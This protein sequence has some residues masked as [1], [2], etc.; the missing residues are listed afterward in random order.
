[1]KFNRSN[2]KSKQRGL[3]LNPYRYATSGPPPSDAL[4]GRVVVLQH[5]D[6]ADGSTTFTDSSGYAKTWSVSG[7]AQI[8]SAQSVFGGSSGQFDG[9]G[10][11]IY[12]ADFPELYLGTRNFTIEGRAR[13]TGAAATQYLMGQC[14]A[15]GLNTTLSI[16]IS[17][18]AT[19][20][21]KA[22]CCSG[23]TEIGAC[24]SA[25]QAVDTWFA[26]SYSRRGATFTLAINGVSVATATSSAAVNNSVD[27]FAIGCL[28][29]FN[30]LYFNGWQDEVRFTIGAAR[31]T[32]P[33]TLE[34]VQF[35]TGPAGDPYYDITS[36]LLHGD[37]TDGS[38]TFTD[39]SGTPKT[40]TVNGNAQIDTAQSQFGGASMLF[41]G[42]GDWLQYAADLSTFDFGS[43]NFTIECWVRPASTGVQYCI[44]ELSLPNAVNDSQQCFTLFVQPTNK[45]YNRATIGSS[46]F[47]FVGTQTLTAGA[48][49]H[50]AFVRD[51]GTL[52]QFVNGVASGT[53]AISGSIN[54]P[55]GRALRI[56]KYLNTPTVYMNG[57]ID[58]VRITTAVARY[59]SAFT[60]PAAAFP[61]S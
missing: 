48:F 14:A 29:D 58:E 15:T 8:D 27:S 31:Y 19:N 11:R 49:N 61:N 20:Q 32:Y 40:P 26:W 23:A 42:T 12:V 43:G 22:I 60:P 28:G 59:T 18:T 38:T 17:R 47:G 3:L 5:F 7:N 2:P 57:W 1:M 16:G 13:F 25:A 39:N 45:I 21:L 30:G 51:G 46:G 4:Y 37:G 52:R 54:V 34:T 6:G 24:T 33:Y 53:L 41:D 10:D 50:V 56:G 44:M 35:P 9:A 36:L 55:T